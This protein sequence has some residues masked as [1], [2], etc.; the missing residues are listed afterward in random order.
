MF[1]THNQNVS[2]SSHVNAVT[3]NIVKTYRDSY[4]NRF[5]LGSQLANQYFQP[6]SDTVVIQITL[7]GDMEVIAELIDRDKYK[8]LFNE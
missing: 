3:G 7:C 4:F 1:N 8:K 6:Y 5:H 2:V